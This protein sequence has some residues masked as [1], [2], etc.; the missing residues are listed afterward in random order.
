MNIA[1]D[2]NNHLRSID[3]F[4]CQSSS[5][6][7]LFHSNCVGRLIRLI[8][9]IRSI[10]SIRLDLQWRGRLHS[11][12]WMGWMGWLS[13]IVGSLRAPSALIITHLNSWYLQNWYTLIDEQ[14]VSAECIN[15]SGFISGSCF[16]WNW[17]VGWC[18]PWF[19]FSQGGRSCTGARVATA[20]KFGLGRKF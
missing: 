11:Y 17:L 12:M 8:R 4:S 7:T 20:E 13:W 14:F 18:F 2:I 5:I 16:R 19:A 9:S 3:L 15:F 6:P 1:P 10:R